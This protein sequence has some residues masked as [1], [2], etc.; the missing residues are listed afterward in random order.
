MKRFSC[1]C[2]VGGLVPNGLES[3]GLPDGGW[4][5]PCAVVATILIAKLGRHLWRYSHSTLFVGGGS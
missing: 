4:L 2:T 5:A 3:Y 1:V